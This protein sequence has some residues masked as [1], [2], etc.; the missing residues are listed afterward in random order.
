[1]SKDKMTSLGLLWLRVLMGLG[2]MSHGYPK[3]F[4][5]HMDRMVEGVAGM[6]FPLPVVFAWAA[7][8]SEFV[9]GILVAIGLK[10]RIAAAFIFMT[11]AVA[12]FVA[13]RADPL[14]V[15][16]LAFAYLTVAGALIL[17]GPGKFSLDRS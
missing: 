3:I 13:H 7:A 2:I 14:Q 6:G 15:K 8:L 1:M 10:T 12:G 11:M 17:T 16:E 4:G 9:G 5:G